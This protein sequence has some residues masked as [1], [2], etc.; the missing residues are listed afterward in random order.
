MGRVC[1]GSEVC[2]SLFLPPDQRSNSTEHNKAI[3]HLPIEPLSS[4]NEFFH[5]Y[6][7]PA[8]TH[9]QHSTTVQE[10]FACQAEQHNIFFMLISSDNAQ[11]VIVLF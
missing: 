4:C 11:P 1:F 8:A 3:I 2:L 10:M 6:R 5:A 7:A 9:S